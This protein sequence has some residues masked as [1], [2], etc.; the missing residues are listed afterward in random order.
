MLINIAF[1]MGFSN[2]YLVG[3]DCNYS[4]PTRHIGEYDKEAVY[5]KAEQIQK[6]MMKSYEVALDYAKS[7][8]IVFLM[9]QEVECS[10]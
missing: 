6:K 8:Q 4:G 7:N 3:C 2:V 10:K 9:Q 1:Y 5:D